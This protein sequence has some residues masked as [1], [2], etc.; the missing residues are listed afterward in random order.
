MRDNPGIGVSGATRE[1]KTATATVVGVT[2]FQSEADRRYPTLNID[3]EVEPGQSGVSPPSR[4][5]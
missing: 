1:S 2:R 4:I 3:P 5:A